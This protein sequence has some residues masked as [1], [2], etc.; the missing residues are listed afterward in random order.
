MKDWT[1]H[2]IGKHILQ[3]ALPIAAG[4]LFQTLYLLIDLY[5]V[6]RV[7]DAALAAG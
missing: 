7:G 1:A 2:S 6:A 3:M 4:M 5:F